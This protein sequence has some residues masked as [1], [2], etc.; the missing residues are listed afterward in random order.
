MASLKCGGKC[1]ADSV[2]LLCSGSYEVNIFISD[3]NKVVEGEMVKFSD[4]T[5]LG[6]NISGGKLFEKEQGKLEN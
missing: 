4:D 2:A 6:T 1:R 3:L 5:I